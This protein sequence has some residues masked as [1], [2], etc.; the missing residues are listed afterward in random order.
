MS[1]RKWKEIQAVLSRSHGITSGPFRPLSLR[2]RELWRT[3]AR[4][5][6]LGNLL[7]AG[8]ARA[9]GGALLSRQA[10][11]RDDHCG[12]GF[13]SCGGRHRSRPRGQATGRIRPGCRGVFASQG[14]REGG[15]FSQSHGLGEANTLRISVCG[16]GNGGR[17]SAPPDFLPSRTP[18]RSAPRA[19]GASN[20]VPHLPPRP[21][22]FRFRDPI[23][24]E[25]P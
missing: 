23:A 14:L 24:G 17:L 22:W 6:A 4:I 7:P 18:A 11:T 9:M 5:H 21:R 20:D 3:R 8:R 12:R 10:N 15:R 13:R 2:A 1:L 25:M 16:R 19:S